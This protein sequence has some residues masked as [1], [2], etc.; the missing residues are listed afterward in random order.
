MNLIIKMRKLSI[1]LLSLPLSLAVIFVS[2]CQSNSVKNV[3]Q[4]PV[5]GS[6]SHTEN[7]VKKV[8]LRASK[9]LG[10]R[11]KVSGGRQIT[12]TRYD[13]DK[14]AVIKIEY[15][16]KHYNIYHMDS[17]NLKSSK[18]ARKQHQ[19]WITKLDSHIRSLSTGI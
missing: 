7:N 14:M 4:S 2:G 3:I 18:K 12:A 5:Y 15:T 1:L 8:I 13:G 17:S 11:T 6:G 9:D 10:W 16:S 19:A